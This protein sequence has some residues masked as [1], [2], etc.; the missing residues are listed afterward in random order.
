MLAHDAVHGAEPEARAPG[1]GGEEGVEGAL[2]LVAAH[3][4]AR[5]AHDDA[6][7]PAALGGRDGQR[8]AIRHG[9]EG[10]QEEVQEGLREPGL[11]ATHRWELGEG[12]LDPYRHRAAVD[13]RL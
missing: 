11:V 6:D 8:A 4:V 2:H 3:T 1:L 5:V 9:V 13:S 10:V 7:L 12:E